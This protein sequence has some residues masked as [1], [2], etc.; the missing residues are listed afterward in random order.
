MRKNLLGE[1]QQVRFGGLATRKRL[2]GLLGAGALLLSSLSAQAQLSGAKSIPGDYATVAAAVTAL[3]AQGVGTGGVTF[4][5]APG[6]TETAAN[7]LITASGTAANPIVFQKGAGTGASPVITGGTGVSTTLDAIF[8]LQGADYVTFDGLTLVDPAAN[9]TATTQIEWGFALLKTSTPA[10]DGCQNVVIRNC[11]I[12]LQKGTATSGIYSANHT[13]ASTTALAPTALSGTNS[14][15]KFY[16]NTI[17]RVNNGIYVA[18]YAAASPYLYYDQG[19]EI[20]SVLSGTA[21]TGNTITDYGTT[22]T[23]YGIYSIYQHGVKV[24]GNTV[25]STTATTTTG[26]TSTLYG[27]LVTT[28][29]SADILGNNVTVNTNTATSTSYGIQNGSG[30][31]GLNGAASTVNM[32]NNSLSMNSTTTTSGVF[33]GVYNT[34]SLPNL[35]VFGNTVSNW[36]RTGTSAFNYLLYISTSPTATLNVYNNTIS[37]ITTTG[38]TSGIYGYYGFPAS[39]AATQYYGNTIQ[40]VTCDGN[41][42]YGMYLSGGGNVDVYRNRVS[43]LTANGAT[44]TIYGIYTTGTTTTLTNNLIGDFKAPAASNTTALT[45]LYLAGGTTVN[46]QYN[47]IYLN[48]SSSGANF[49]TSGIYF[50]STATTLV[51]LRNNVVVNTSTAAGTGS[52]VALR[53]SGGSAGVAPINLTTATNNNLYYAGSP[54]TTGNLIYGE[55][56]GTLTNGLST[57]AD[58]KSFLSDREVV[59]VTE[60]VPFVSTV[61]TNANFL[62]V[63]TTTPTQVEGG[64]TPISGI[65]TD[66]ANA[67]RSATTPDLGAYE[68]TY[69][70]LDLTGPAILNATLSNTNSTANRTLVVTISDAAGVATGANA[71]RLYYRKGTSGAYVFVNATS[72]SGNQYTFTLN[73]T[74][75][76]GVTTGDVV[77]YYVAAQDLAT[78]PNVSTAPNGGGSGATPPGTTAPAT[79]GSFQIVGVLSGIY[80]V[81]TSTP[82]AGTPADRVYPTLTAAANAYNVNVLGGA[83]TFYLLDA[84]YSTA[85]TF[86]IVFNAN[87]SASATNTARFSPY[88]GVTSTITGAANSLLQFKATTY[89]TF[90]GSNVVGGTQRNLTLNNTQTTAAGVIIVGSQGAGNGTSFVALRNMNLRGGA[91]GNSASFGI[92]V[93][94]T[95]TGTPATGTGADNDNLTIQNNSISGVYYGIY[96]GGTAAV[97]AGGLDG[98]TVSNNLIGPATAAAA[99]NIGNTGL[100]L[101]NAVNPVVTGNTVRNVVASATTYGMNF[102]AGVNGATV[103]Q[104]VVSNVSTSST[105]AYGIY[106]GTNFINGV[107]DRNRIETVVGAPTGGYGGKGIDIATGNA[108]SNLVVSNNLVSGMNGSGWST[109]TSDAIIGIRVSSG[110]GITVAYNSVNLYGNYLTVPTSTY[111]SAALFVN[112]GATNLTVANNVLVNSL[113]TGGTTAS[114]AYSFYTYA[115]T[116]AY[117][118][119]NSNDYYVAGAQ[120]VLANVG[121]TGGISATTAV[122]TL[123]ALQTATGKDASSVSV[124]PIF[125]SN[126]DLQSSQPALNNVGTPV[127]GITT[128][129]NG[130]A[131]SATTPDIGAYEFTPQPI[132]IAAS[133]LV[134]PV[135]SGTSTC[136]GANTPVTVQVRNNGTATL[137]FATNPLTVTVVITG[138]AGTTPQTLTQVISTGTLASTATQ[139]VTLTSLANFTTLGTYTFSV[140]T[141]VTGDQNAA[142]NVLTPAAT[143]NVVAPVAGTLSPSTYSICVSG[144]TTLT[145][146][147]AANG[148]IQYQSSTSA[149]GPFTNIS[150]ATSASYTTPT[151]TSTT[152][153]RAV[154]SC[155]A[156]SATSNVSAVLV[157]NPVISAAPSPVS[158]CAG[159]T[160]SLSATVPTGVNVRYF[161]TATGGTAIG[162]GNPFVTPALT[163][164][165]TYYAEAFAG[166]Q[167]NVG[168]PSTTGTDGTNT[169]GGLYFTATAPTVIT[170]VTVYRTANAAA[171]TAT[172]QLLN[173]STTTGTPVASVTVPVP[174]N[175]TAAISPTVLTLN[176]AVPAAGQYTLYLS[177]ATPSLI[178]DFS[179]T[180]QPATAYP[181]T[182]PSGL[183]TITNSTLG[184]DYYYFFYNWQI[185]S[186]CIGAT[187]TPIQ[188]NVTPGLVASLPVSAFTSCGQTPYQ[189]NGSIA[190]TATGATYTSTGTGT[191][192]PNATTLNATYTPSAADVAAGTVTI[193]LTPT[194][195]AAPCTSTGRV[196]LTLQAAPNAAFSYPA[197]TYCTNSPVT[198]APV[199]APGAVAGTFGTTG[200]GLRIDPVTGVINL[201]NTNIDGTFTVTNTVAGSG[202]CASFTA[203]T[204]FTVIFGIG[205]PTL[206]ATP[207][208]GGAV[209][210]ST[211]TLAGATYQFFK[212]TPAVAVGPPSSANTLLLAAGTQSGSYT[213]VVTATTGCSSIPSAPVSVV[214]TGTQT[215]TRNGV[216]LLVYPNPTPNGNLTVELRGT[217]ANASQFSVF[218]SLG[219]TVRTGTLGTGLESLSLTNLASGVY[220]LRVQ[221]AEGVL[222]QRIVRE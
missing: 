220:T 66:Y 37:D 42:L 202:A 138:P 85:E 91:N 129:F 101:T 29:G 19:N 61:G 133:A 45:G 10:V 52:T 130:A 120:G 167:E 198:V 68:G 136:F 159:A 106:L 154:V 188:V 177:A 118:V 107:V 141:T 75:I 121:G 162:T 21:A 34:S 56:T 15:N 152:Y 134:S 184:T 111:L 155:G 43:G 164:S 201:A 117:N 149:T 72:V 163:A 53:R 119:L 48:G 113:V 192:S 114:V 123:A 98:L 169:I 190:G 131:R 181:Y 33:Y 84:T 104:N 26:P 128:D 89:L 23:A 80:Y 200:I 178:R 83:V 6:Y 100:Y 199:L 196:V 51:T 14:N 88:T 206:T 179:S 197:G 166:N 70:P 205:Q 76:G 92:L 87:A 63:S 171:G 8:T 122:A 172:I 209:L 28:G 175:T 44:A 9:A 158:T 165:T 31:N 46:A 11:S 58:Y 213:V 132:D 203:T 27:I 5:I 109:L 221:T 140:T 35:N 173:G 153:Y 116:S 219:Q 25:T 94:A 142:N 78:T 62:K 144:A 143:L 20:G 13:P 211:P 174:A 147:G 79:P 86:P 208:A 160:A 185:G 93:S 99:D 69:Q 151:L 81:G 216:S 2:L 191:F 180:P 210:L 17:S 1:P 102:P 127:A 3:N 105:N 108:T 74:L 67:T 50:T 47:T 125:A 73:Y 186:E 215:A 40:N 49:G 193:T 222:T 156:N 65:T 126:T 64:G 176:L 115:P 60:N 36:N 195:P 12:T 124:D 110:S 135:N 168:K 4:N 59:S 218:N 7:V 194:G 182:S 183:V 82:P 145:L 39:T 24:Q 22:T 217:K 97:S 204:T 214:V 16:G 90:D 146:A 32:G 30:V 103:S 161:T 157:N 77:Q 96:A 95:P 41:T 212:G 137:N 189:L 150:G 38:A 112:T 55:G 18:G 170:N 207:Q 148:D 139:N 54:A 57:L 71:P 187:R